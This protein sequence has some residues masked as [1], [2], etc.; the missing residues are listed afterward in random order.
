M[1]I[2]IFE[3]SIPHCDFKLPEICDCIQKCMSDEHD[4]FLLHFVT[5]SSVIWDINLY[6]VII[7]SHATVFLPITMPKYLK[8]AQLQKYRTGAIRNKDTGQL[9]GKSR[10]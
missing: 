9:K 2:F 5:L 3:D 7:V 8:L 10:P 1:T 4:T 6:P